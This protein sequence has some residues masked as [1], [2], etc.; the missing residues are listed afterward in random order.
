MKKAS[1]LPD[2]VNNLRAI[3]NS[4]KAEIK[5]TQVEAAKELN[6]SQGAISHYLN[7]ITELGPAA[8]IKFANFLGVDPLEIDPT[9]KEHLPN[10]A[11]RVLRYDIKDINTEIKEKTYIPNVEKAFWVR[12]STTDFKNSH[13]F[14]SIPESD[15]HALVCPAKEYPSAQLFL[16]AFRRK[17]AAEFR[18]VTD[19]PDESKVQSMYAVL[20]ISITTAPA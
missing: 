8:V 4:K 5:F 2:S 16:V 14:S 7:N 15:I 19:L 6:W 3:W 12:A 1:E 11:K 9:I 17:K 10:I 13:L 18:P 20:E